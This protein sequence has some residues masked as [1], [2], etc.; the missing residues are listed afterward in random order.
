MK[1]QH[2]EDYRARRKAAYPPIGNQLDAVMKL[3]QALRDAGTPLPP[4]TAQWLAECEGVK[5]RFNKP[6]EAV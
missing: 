4:E 5:A 3:A 2:K 1:I 6:K